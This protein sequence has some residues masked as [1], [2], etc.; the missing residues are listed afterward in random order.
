MHNVFYPVENELT[1]VLGRM[2][3]FYKI[4]AGDL[5][6]F[7]HL[8]KHIKRYICPA[9]VL[10][11]A[12][13]YSKITEKVVS[14]AEVI[15]FIYL[16]SAVHTD[17]NENDINKN[18]YTRERPDPK[19]GSQYPVL[20]GDYLY[21]R[22][23]TTLCDA[24]IIKYLDPLSEVICLINE[25]GIVRYSNEHKSADAG[26]DAALLEM[27]VLLTVCCQLAGEMAGAGKDQQ[28]SLSKMGLSLGMAIEMADVQ[29]TDQADS[30][31]KEALS[32]L[33]HLIPGKGRDNLRGLLLHLMD[34]NSG[35]KR[36]VC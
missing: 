28:I 11:V 8:E 4:R 35:D 20:V 30:F 1:Q 31:F 33:D 5:R 13:V 32:H 3:I 36:I 14:L 6:Q 27:A 21:G 15:Q 18:N 23:F 17:V 34:K 10:F 26:G 12:K 25:C 2:D 19:D 9:L 22:F 16:A 29:H 24:D 7:S